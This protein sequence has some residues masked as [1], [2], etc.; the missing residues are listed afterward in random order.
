MSF[1]LGQIFKSMRCLLEQ[2]RY[3][4]DPKQ[5]PDRYLKNTSVHECCQG[6]IA[7]QTGLN[8]PGEEQY[9]SNLRVLKGFCNGCVDFLL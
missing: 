5:M 4:A 1:R 6:N 2:A 8:V 7:S 9:F 3:Y